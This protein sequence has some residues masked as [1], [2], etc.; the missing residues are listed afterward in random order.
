MIRSKYADLL[1]GLTSGVAQAEAR[2]ALISLVK[3]WRTEAP[4]VMPHA[5]AWAIRAGN[6]T[7]NFH[8]ARQSL[9]IVWTGPASKESSFR[10][11]DQ[12][13]LST[14]LHSEDLLVQK[15]VIEVRARLG[16]S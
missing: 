9:E 15:P 16:L 6:A 4:R 14:K 11:T 7:D 3:Y 8:R 2:A 1:N 13:L 5:L 12:A 10:R